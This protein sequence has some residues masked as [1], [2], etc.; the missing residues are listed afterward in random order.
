MEFDAR[1]LLFIYCQ[2]IIVYMFGANGLSQYWK[3]FIFHIFYIQFSSDTPHNQT[4]YKIKLQHFVLIAL[5]IKGM[6]IF[7]AWSFESNIFSVKGRAQKVIFIQFSRNELSFPNL[8][9][10]RI[11]QIPKLSESFQISQKLSK[12]KNFHQ[13]FKFNF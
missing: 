13:K 2:K 11:S 7:I 4:I 6:K 1:Y 8:N 12:K 3:L 9:L 10:S 5:I